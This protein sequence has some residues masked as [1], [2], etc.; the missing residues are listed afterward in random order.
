MDTAFT[1]HW[2]LI[3][4]HLELSSS[5]TGDRFWKFVDDGSSARKSILRINPTSRSTME[6]KGELDEG[7][8]SVA[9]FVVIAV[10]A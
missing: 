5:P 2:P 8:S 7:N 9:V 10:G 4:L 6:G 3:I 1:P